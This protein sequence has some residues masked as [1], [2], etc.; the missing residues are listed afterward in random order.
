VSSGASLDY[1]TG[2]DGQ[3]YAV[4]GEVG[5]STSKGRTPEET[6]MRAQQIRAAAL[7]PAD[8]SAQD[9]SVAA[10]ATQMAAEARVE[11]A[12]EQVEASKVEGDDDSAA[13]SSVK[14]ETGGRVGTEERTRERNAGA[15]SSS[16]S[17]AITDA[18]TALG[19]T[20]AR[21]LSPSRAGQTINIFA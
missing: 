20:I 7:A 13:T 19:N 14:N 6:L 8:P 15:S 4:A 5:I 1:T 18:A 9:R 2:P 11:L 17:S 10:A 3:R 21:S 12:R 16:P